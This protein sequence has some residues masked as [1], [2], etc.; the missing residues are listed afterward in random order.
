MPCASRRRPGRVLRRAVHD[1]TRRAGHRDAAEDAR[2]A[3]H[4][5][6]GYLQWI[7]RPSAERAPGRA[8]SWRAGGRG[9]RPARGAGAGPPGSARARSAS[10]DPPPPPRR[11]PP[12]VLRRCGSS[13]PRATRGGRWPS[14]RGRPEDRDR[15]AE[16]AAAADRDGYLAATRGSS[17]ARGFRADVPRA[18][19]G[20]PLPARSMS[21]PRHDGEAA[22]RQAARRSAPHG[23]SVDLRQ[24]RRKNLTPYDVLIIA[25]M[26]ERETIE[27]E[28][29]RLVA[30]VIYNRLRNRMPLG[31]DATIRYGLDV[32]ARSPCGSRSSRATTRT[33]RAT[34]LG[35]PP[36]P[37]AN[38]G[39]P[40]MQAAANP[41]P[42]DYLFFVRKPTR[43]TTSSRPASRSS[44][45]RHASTA[46]D[47]DSGC[48]SL[49]VG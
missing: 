40:S 2:A 44:T 47:V 8:R 38:P 16:G 42:V 30:A 15:E 20:L 5:L 13:S 23:H 48:R 36:T 28:E 37:I 41:A 1:H 46:T 34:G 7:N 14:G 24:A 25:S 10:D 11:R 29:R 31:I 35:L 12:P 18:R 3:A 49:V 27:P 33:T 21:S 26:V 22:R 9:R 32:P 6:S 17:A 19:G 43:C 45:R 39:L 4:L